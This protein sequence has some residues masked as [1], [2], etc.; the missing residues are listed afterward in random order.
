[1][2]GFFNVMHTRLSSI[3]TAQWA[4]HKLRSQ[5]YQVRIWDDYRQLFAE[6]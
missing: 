1:M 2:N 3:E 5:G 6:G 4:S